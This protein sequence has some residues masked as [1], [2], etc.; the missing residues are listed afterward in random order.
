MK[1]KR[2]EAR[3]LFSLGHLDKLSQ[4]LCS[5]NCCFLGDMSLLHLPSCYS[6]LNCSFWAMEITVSSSLQNDRFSTIPALWQRTNHHFLPPQCECTWYL[7]NS[8]EFQ[9][10]YCGAQPPFC[11]ATVDL[12]NSILLTLGS[13]TLL[14]SCE[15]GLKFLFLCLTFAF[16]LLQNIP[17]RLLLNENFTGFCLL[18]LAGQVRPPG[19]TPACL[20]GAPPGLCPTKVSA[21]GLA[22]PPQAPVSFWGPFTPF[23]QGMR[24]VRF[25]SFILLCPKLSYD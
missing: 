11:C 6:P 5:S 15:S 21:P 20:P 3:V 4:V 1:P 19:R 8:L 2:T 24:G 23:Q 25:L 14:L 12:T 22:S 10:D 16:R 7:V 18:P 9:H 17:W 13:H